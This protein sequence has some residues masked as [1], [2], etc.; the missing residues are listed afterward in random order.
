M[1]AETPALF[2]TGLLIALS[3]LCLP[4]TSTSQAQDD[5]P[6]R[7][8]G[9]P[10]RLEGKRIVFTNWFF[11]RPGSHAWVDDD[12]NV[13]TAD[14]AANIGDWG[15][16][17]RTYD[18]PR[19]VRIAVRPA[20]RRS[21]ILVPE[22]PWEKR[23]S[24]TVLIQ[25]GDRL[26]FWGTCPDPCYLESRDG[27]TWERP[28]L[29]LVEFAGNRDNNL[30]PGVPGGFLFIDPSAPPQQRYKA[31]GTDTI[32]E[33]EFAAY[34][35]ERPGDYDPR[36]RR[37]DVGHVYA[38]RGFVSADGFNWT[39]LPRPL[40]VEH[41]DTQNT[42][43]YDPV[44]GKYVLYTRTWWVGDQDPSARG[45]V[46]P[47]AAWIAP[48]RRSIGRSESDTFGDFP[49]SQAIAAPPPDFL[50]SEVLYTNCKTTMPGQ[51][52]NHLMFP[53]VWNMD[54]DA[55]RLV[56]MSSTDGRVWHWV[57][58]GTVLDTGAFGTFDGG[59]I[60][61][62]PNLVEF[63]NGDFALPYNGY[64][65]PHKYPRGHEGFPPTLGFAVW[66][67]GRICAVEAEG[68]GE[69]TT[70]GF[71]PPGNRLRI[72]AE[73]RRGG[74]IVVEVCAL[75]RGCMDLKAIP[76]RSFDDCAPVIGD[77]FRT[78]VTWKEGE[79]LGVPVGQPLALRFRMNQASIYA[80]EF[81]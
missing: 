63:A 6:E 8:S 54:S 25:D 2:L 66:P 77:Q 73:T 58:G 10:Y 21:D 16:H 72:N 42:G 24:V 51:P 36:A 78:L 4:A 7:R 32:S 34:L 43:H 22:Q 49:V 60:F 81:E 48:G 1:P 18:M 41:A 11:V 52:D 59:A 68:L 37:T 47:D 39:L 56:M 62:S 75:S 29:G 70:V 15:A 65:F 61:A 44:T 64:R 35:H 14:R 13:V 17:F 67:K 50:P 5:Q 69:F 38:L 9:E 30:C 71:I 79:D 57:P 31:L 26:R 74:W 40:S 55:T 19:G 12:G 3:L 33:E 28:T 27:V 76:G 23:F 20:E 80:L 46:S 45:A 53:A